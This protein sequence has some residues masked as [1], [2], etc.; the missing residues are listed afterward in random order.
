MRCLWRHLANW[1]RLN[2]FTYSVSIYWA[3]PMCQ[4]QNRHGLCSHGVYILGDGG[5]CEQLLIYSWSLNNVGVR[6]AKRPLSSYS[7]KST[8][9]FGLPPNL[10]TILEFNTPSMILPQDLCSCSSL[11]NIPAWIMGMG[12]YHTALSLLSCHF[13][14]MSSLITPYKIIPILCPPSLN[15]P[16]L[17][18]IPPLNILNILCTFSFVSPYAIM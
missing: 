6:G 16:F 17:Q 11:Y 14:A 3:T 5:E 1:E 10:T 13:S 9:N 7:W 18:H 4:T 15:Y 12:Y 2:K 8:Y